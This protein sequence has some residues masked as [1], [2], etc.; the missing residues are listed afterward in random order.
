M[1][2]ILN[3]KNKGFTFLEVIFAIFIM[4]IGIVGALIAVQYGT[5]SATQAKARLTAAYLAQEGIEI[6]RNIRDTNWIEQR[7]A[8]TTWDEGLDE[9]DYEADY[10]DTETEYPSLNFCPPPCNYNDLSFL[11]KA[12][13]DFYNYD[14]GEVTQFKRKITIEKPATSTLKVSV[15]VYW[16]EGKHSLTTQE[17]L[18]NWR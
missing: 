7:V 5:S 18:Y 2:Q 17:I 4:I 1:F 8:S 6:I 10:K 13:E 15:T 16:D 9:G 14:T 3:F 12:N 11:K